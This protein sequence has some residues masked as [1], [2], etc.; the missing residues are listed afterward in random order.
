GSV[1]RFAVDREGGVT[2]DDRI[3]LL[4]AELLLAVLLDDFVA[5][6]RSRVG[7]DAECGYAERLAHGLPHECP[8]DRDPLDLVQ[9]ENLHDV[10]RNAW[11]TTGSSASLPSTRSSRFSTPPQAP[12]VGEPSCASRSWASA[13][14][15][16]S[17]GPQP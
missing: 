3:D 1:D 14:G 7:V 8:E 16:P 11:R 15:S 2:G 9:A 10:S 17:S 4:V 13:R 5:G 6:V 12:R